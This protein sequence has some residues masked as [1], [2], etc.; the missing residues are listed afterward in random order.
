MDIVKVLIEFVITFI[1]IYLVYYFLVIKKCKKDSKIVPAEVNII[2][3]FHKIDIKKI[4][5]YQM[6]QV[7]SIVTTLILS[8]IITL[9]G[10][11]FDNTIILLVFGT[12]IS[13]VV[14]IICYRIIGKHYEKIS[15]KNKKNNKKSK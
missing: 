4:N 3:M 5:L 9:I 15:E 8:I 2:L 11:F 6:I 14:A 10:V 13:L 12:L 7:V 1:V